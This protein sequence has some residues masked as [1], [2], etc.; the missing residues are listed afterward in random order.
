M[1][2]YSPAAALAAGRALAR[3]GLRWFEDFCDPLDFET[4]AALAA[5][6]APPLAAG[7]ALFS[8]PDARNLLRYGGLRPGRDALLFDPA[9]CYGLPEY[10]RIVDVFETAGWPRAAFLPHGGHLFSLHVTAALGLGGS[11]ANPL[12][13]QPCGGFSDGLLVVHGRAT[14]PEAPGIGFETRAALGSMFREV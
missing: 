7:E 6:Y 14:L 1:N 2:R 8:L 13:F 3:Y 10:S 5:E 12:N 9:H 4:H 11:E